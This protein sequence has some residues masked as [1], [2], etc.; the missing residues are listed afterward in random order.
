MEEGAGFFPLLLRMPGL[1]LVKKA[2]LEG[3]D[4]VGWTHRSRSTPGEPSQKPAGEGN[5]SSVAS[6]VA[7]NLVQSD[8]MLNFF[9]CYNYNHV[10]HSIEYSGQSMWISV[11]RNDWLPPH[12]PPKKLPSKRNPPKNN[13]RKNVLFFLSNNYNTLERVMEEVFHAV[14]KNIAIKKK[15]KW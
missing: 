11:K 6:V 7:R 9:N 5:P 8:F 13:K 12:P 4:G 15:S 3:R 10:K 14:N 1:N 2:R